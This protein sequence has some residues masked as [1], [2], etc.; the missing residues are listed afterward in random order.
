MNEDGNKGDTG[1]HGGIYP[2]MCHLF[3]RTAG[4]LRD[5]VAKRAGVAQGLTL[6]KSPDLHLVSLVAHLDPVSP[7]RQAVIPSFPSNDELI[8]TVYESKRLP[9]SRLSNVRGEKMDSSLVIFGRSQACRAVRWR[10]MNVC[11]RSKAIERW[12][13]RL[14]CFDANERR[15]D[16]IYRVIEK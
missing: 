14:C 7:I 12:C 9:T 5:L 6:S 10:D 8:V 1:C 16:G 2:P 13:C 15:L 4:V 3:C 11:D